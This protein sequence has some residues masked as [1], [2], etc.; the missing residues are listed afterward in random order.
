MK[1]NS[2][3]ATPGK[4]IRLKDFDPRD[5]G[6]YKSQHHAQKTLDNNIERLRHYQDL[7]YSE[8]SYSLL[9]ILQAMDA[10]GKDGTINHV[11][12]GVNP[13]G[14]EVHAFKQPSQQELDHDF[15][16]R[17]YKEMPE[18]GKI[19]IFNRSYYEEVLV[20]RVH[21]KFLD[22][23][24]LPGFDGSN[25]KF[26]KHR[27]ESINDMEKHLARNGTVILKFF[28]HLSKEEQARRLLERIEDSAKNWKFS[29]A[30]LQERLRWNDYMACY[31]DMINHTS[32]RHAGWYIIPADNKWFTHLCVSDIIVKTL[33]DLNLKYPA[34][35]AE[36][37][38][39][40]REAREALTRI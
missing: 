3:C 16:W 5:T 37:K 22:A 19:G 1:D 23:E 20:T 29:E 13:S 6:K 27:F 26:W 35:S 24:R 15:L 32:T 33:K 7:L 36:Q 28:L 30:D 31:E 40:L 38:E 34:V 14:C 2:F 25:E 10:A 39:R 11:M 12:S 21:P 9:I 4:R 17:C 18:R 8:H